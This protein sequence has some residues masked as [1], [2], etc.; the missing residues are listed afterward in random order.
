MTEKI[1]ATITA[2]KDEV[3][4]ESWVN[5]PID[6]R[7]KIG[8]VVSYEI[9]WQKRASSNSYSSKSG[10]VF[11]VGMQTKRIINCVVFSTNCKKCEYKPAENKK[12][13]EKKKEGDGD[14]DREEWWRECKTYRGRF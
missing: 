11:V 7:E 8:L 1:K 6:Q 10:H 3:Y 2:E 12:K 13:K 14:G 4:Y 9:G 5:K